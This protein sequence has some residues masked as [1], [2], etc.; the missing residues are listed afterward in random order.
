[1]LLTN[2]C[3]PIATFSVLLCGW[4]D[5]TGSCS[6]R[7]APMACLTGEHHQTALSPATGTP[8][9]LPASSLRWK[10]PPRRRPCS[11]GSPPRSPHLP[12][13]CPH[14][15]RWAHHQAS[16]RCPCKGNIYL[17]CGPGTHTPTAPWRRWRLGWT[18]TL[19]SVSSNYDIG[20][21]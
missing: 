3:T 14:L 2:P 15:C 19:G 5:L 20:D 21:G 16:S 18:G 8:P 17:L 12:E 6:G 13:L 4:G 10:H 1:M 9:I 11:L 7:L